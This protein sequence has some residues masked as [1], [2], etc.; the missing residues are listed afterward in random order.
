[1]AA[2]PHA[3]AVAV[4]VCRVRDRNQ[5]NVNASGRYSA[6]VALGRYKPNK[7]VSSGRRNAHVCVRRCVR[8]AV[9]DRL[10]RSLRHGSVMRGEHGSNLVSAVSN[11]NRRNPEVRPCRAAV[12]SQ[13]AIPPLLSCTSNRCGAT[14]G[15][16]T[17]RGGRGRLGLQNTVWTSIILYCSITHINKKTNVMLYISTTLTVEQHHH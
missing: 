14:G 11:H 7:L 1:M 9:T 13:V 17:A 6:C 15:V 8:P 16:D 10:P 5:R 12:A 2:P 3:L 4:A